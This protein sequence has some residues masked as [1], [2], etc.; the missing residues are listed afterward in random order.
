MQGRELTDEH[1]SLAHNILK[2]QF[3][4][5]DGLQS[6]LLAQT[7]GFIPV[8]HEGIQIHHVPERSHWVTSSCCGQHISVYDSK[9]A[10]FQLSTSLSH[11]L[12]LIYRLA[13][14]DDC[15]D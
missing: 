11:Q 4:H 2:K 9:E 3:P 15:H 1:I 13:V 10:G 7:N 12:A 14:E 5:I 6:P 8:Q